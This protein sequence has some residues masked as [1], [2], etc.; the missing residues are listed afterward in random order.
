VDWDGVR[1]AAPSTALEYFHILFDK[2]P[3]VRCNGAL[4]ETLL[5]S[6]QDKFAKNG[7]DLML[8]DLFGNERDMQTQ[9]ARPVLRGFEAKGLF[10]RPPA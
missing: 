9:P 3:P 4:C 1:V 7:V 5:P 8:G 10:A 2:H 6:G